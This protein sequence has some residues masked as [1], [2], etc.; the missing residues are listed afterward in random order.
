MIHIYLLYGLLLL[1]LARVIGCKTHTYI[2]Y[3]IYAT[4]GS[5]VLIARLP[6]L[7]IKFQ[8]RTKSLI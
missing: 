4:L 2:T 1:I 8:A 3:I 5:T 6:L 7:S